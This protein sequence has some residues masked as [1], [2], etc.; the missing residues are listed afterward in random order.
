MHMIVWCSHGVWGSEEDTECPL[1][2]C[3]PMLEL[4]AQE[5]MPGFV[6]GCWGFELSFSSLHSKCS[7]PVSYLCNPKTI[8]FHYWL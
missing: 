8:H 2:F 4:Q 1:F 7:Y 6:L 3:S 5:A